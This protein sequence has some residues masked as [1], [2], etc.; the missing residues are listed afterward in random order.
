M[1]KYVVIYDFEISRT[2][3]CVMEHI[4]SLKTLEKSLNTVL[5]ELHLIVNPSLA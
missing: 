3:L 5:D 4:D 1:P 2:I